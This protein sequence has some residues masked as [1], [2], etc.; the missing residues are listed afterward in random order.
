[1]SKQK[2]SYQFEG[3]SAWLILIAF[4]WAFG[5]ITLC[6]FHYIGWV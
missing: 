4:F 3:I 6:V 1:M 2:E 5:L